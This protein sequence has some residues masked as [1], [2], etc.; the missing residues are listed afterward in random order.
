[1]CT[2]K[3]EDVGLSE[4]DLQNMLRNCGVAGGDAPLPQPPRIVLSPAA[5]L[6]PV[7]K[8]PKCYLRL[9]EDMPTPRIEDFGISEYTLRLNNDFTMDLLRGQKPA[10]TAG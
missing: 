4:R 8:T 10:K 1:M 7:P 2:P 6:P 9:D 3:L 5:T